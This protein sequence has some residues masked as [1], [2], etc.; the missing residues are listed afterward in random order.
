M[1]AY[2]S[3]PRTYCKPVVSEMTTRLPPSFTPRRARSSIPLRAKSMPPK[4]K[5]L[6]AGPQDVLGSLAA[7]AAVSVLLLLA[8]LPSAEPAELAGGQGPAAEE[9]QLLDDGAAPRH[10]AVLNWDDSG[11]DN[12]GEVLAGV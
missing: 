11:L 1:Q 4:Q 10:V 5:A 3:R 7:A 6:L 12:G 9:T 2:S 8:R